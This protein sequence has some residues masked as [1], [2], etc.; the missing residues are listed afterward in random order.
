LK[1]SNHI[2]IFEIFFITVKDNCQLNVKEREKIIL[3]ILY[4]DM[5]KKVISTYL[6]IIYQF[7]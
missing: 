5:E 7:L 2:I 6:S 4:I 3:I 1:Q